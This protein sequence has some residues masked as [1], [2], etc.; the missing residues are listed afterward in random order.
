VRSPRISHPDWAH[1]GRAAI[2]EF[3]LFGVVGMLFLVVTLF[4]AHNN[5]RSYLNFAA[6][7]GVP[8]SVRLGHAI[9][10][11]AGYLTVV[12]LDEHGKIV[13]EISPER[14]SFGVISIEEEGS[15]GEELQHES[16]EFKCLGE[17]SPLV[18][19]G[20]GIL[21]I[22]KLTLAIIAAEKYNRSSFHRMTE[23]WLAALLV[24]LGARLPEFSFGLAQ[25]RPAS[26]RSFLQEELDQ[27]EFSDRDFLTLLTNDCHN[28]RLAAKYIN[29]LSHQVASPTSIDELISTIAQAYNGSVTPT[30]HGLR[31]VDAVT[32]AYHLLWSGDLRADDESSLGQDEAGECVYFNI[33]SVMP[34]ENIAEILNAH[35]DESEENAKVAEVHLYFQHNDPGPA[36]YVARLAAQRR[37]WLMGRLMEVGFAREQISVAEGPPPKRLRQHCE[38]KDNLSWAG[39]KIK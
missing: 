5:K 1:L 35:Q 15:V 14:S 27:A 6:E 25:I 24:R 13:D 11:K 9:L 30:I 4:E 31:Y 29:M 19:P 20:A 37:D 21:D 17:F 34:K 32:G 39:I 10:V 33:A 2:K 36:A 18:I 23:S 3:A 26:V 12:F 38:K 8:L 16:P 28:V 7:G 22:K